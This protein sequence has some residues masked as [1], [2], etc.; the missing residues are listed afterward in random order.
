MTLWLCCKREPEFEKSGRKRFCRPH[1][2]S[3]WQRMNLIASSQWN[4]I[5]SAMRQKIYDLE[6]LCLFTP[7]RGL[8]SALLWGIVYIPEILMSTWL[9]SESF[10]TLSMKLSG[11][12]KLHTRDPKCVFILCSRSSHTIHP[13]PKWK[14]DL[15]R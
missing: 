12:P 4:T 2:Y 11:V 10:G 8:P 7:T 14:I 15:Y 13:S 1:Q 9:K 3:A 6:T 5:D